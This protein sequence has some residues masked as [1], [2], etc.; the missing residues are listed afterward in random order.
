[1]LSY[2]PRTPSLLTKAVDHAGHLRLQPAASPGR[3]ALH[4]SE[5][6]A[7]APEAVARDLCHPMAVSHR[8]GCGAQ[9]CPSRV[10]QI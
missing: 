1:M 7:Q 3:A 9:V 6:A 10:S 4:Q 5:A 8:A 2:E